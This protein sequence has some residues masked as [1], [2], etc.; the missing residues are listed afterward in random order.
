MNERLFGTQLKRLTEVSPWRWM[1]GHVL[2]YEYNTYSEISLHT[3]IQ[4]HTF[5]MMKGSGTQT[6]NS[7]LIV[8]FKI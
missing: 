6:D 4:M 8:F 2:L 3:H 1:V 5:I 7:T